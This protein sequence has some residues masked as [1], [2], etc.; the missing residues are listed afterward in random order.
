MQS[1]MAAE[2]SPR[3]VRTRSLGRRE[4]IA[5]L[6]HLNGFSEQ[7]RLRVRRVDGRDAINRIF[8]HRTWND[9]G[10][11]PRYSYRNRTD[12]QHRYIG[13]STCS[14]AG[15]RRRF[16]PFAIL[17]RNKRGRGSHRRNET[18]VSAIPFRHALL[19]PNAHDRCCS[20]LFSPAL[21]FLQRIVPRH[22]VI[23]IGFHNPISPNFSTCRGTNPCDGRQPS[24]HAMAAFSRL[25]R[26]R[27][28]AIWLWTQRQ[29]LAV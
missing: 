15:F 9:N 24:R 5:V 6:N 7:K 28:A 23:A 20:A 16:E 14:L 8:N 10:F 18:Q 13:F 19:H 17:R 27:K 4:F 3:A 29:S 25:R 11:V 12:W 22:H 2:L 1:G 26:G 21:L